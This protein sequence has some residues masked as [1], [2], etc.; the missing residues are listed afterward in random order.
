MIS[1]IRTLVFLILALDLCVSTACLCFTQGTNACSSK[2]LKAICAVFD[3]KVM[4]FFA[5]QI[6]SAWLFT[7]NCISHLLQDYGVD[8]VVDVDEANDSEK[9]SDTLS[10]YPLEWQLI[11]PSSSWQAKSWHDAEE[12]KRGWQSRAKSSD[13]VVSCSIVCCNLQDYHQKYYTKANCAVQ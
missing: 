3:L 13:M 6:S 1:C 7:W 12:P 11:T 8:H 9:P 10:S 4:T 2:H 5:E